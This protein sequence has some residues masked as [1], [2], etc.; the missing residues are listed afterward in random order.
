[1][2][3]RVI[4]VRSP[5][6]LPVV[7][8]CVLLCVLLGLVLDGGRARSQAPPLALDEVDLVKASW[9]AGTPLT[10]ALPAATGGDGSYSYGLSVF[11]T[12][13]RQSISAIPGLTFNANADPPTLSGT[14]SA[15]AGFPTRTGFATA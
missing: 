6:K 2:A 13:T 8:V 15:P 11:N 4:A 14:P 1:M 7:A 10:I 3:E 9:V 5:V 12:Q